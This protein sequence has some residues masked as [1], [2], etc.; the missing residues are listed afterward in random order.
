[1]IYDLKAVKFYVRHRD[2]YPETEVLDYSRRGFWA[3]GVETSTFESTSEIDFIG[4]LSPTV[5]LAGYFEDVHCALT[6]MGLPIPPSNDYPEQLQDFLGRS[7]RKEYLGD[8]RCSAKT[9]FIKPVSHKLFTGTIFSNDEF[10]RRKIVTQADDVEVW[11]SDLVNFVSEYRCFILH[12]QIID[13]RRYKGDWAKAPDRSIVEAAVEKMRGSCCAYCLD[14]GIT[15]D[16]RTLLVESND[17][18]A[19]GHYGLNP[20]LCAL[21][22]SARWYEMTSQ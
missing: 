9:S 22:T 19:L 7:I 15:D 20:I 13:C 3:L 8:V 4:D 12:D 11:V 17:A 21:M 5:G 14:W 18:Y 16:G 10:S 2:G 1:M 6:K